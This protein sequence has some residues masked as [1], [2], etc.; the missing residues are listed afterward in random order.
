MKFTK[1]VAILL[2]VCCILIAMVGCNTPGPQGEV[3]PQGAQGVQGPQGEKGETGAQGP[4]GAQGL[5]GEKGETGAQGPQGEKGEDGKSTY[6]IYCEKYGYTGTEEEW[7]QEVYNKLNELGPQDI[8]KIAQAAV[9]TLRSY[10]YSGDLFSSGSA[11]FVDAQGTLVTA[12]HVI[13]GAY[14]LKIETFD[15][16]TY[17]VKN[18]VAFDADRDIALLRVE[19]PSENAFLKTRNSITPGEVAYSFGSSLGFLDGSFASGVIASGLHEVIIDESTDESFKEIQYTAPVSS[20]NSG[21]PILN[22]NGEAIGIVTWGYTIGDSL[23]FAT[24]ISELGELDR[25]YERSV[26]AFFHNTEYYKTKMFEDMYVESEPNNS[27]TTANLFY[28]G[29]SVRGETY[30]GAYDY[31]KITINQ[32]SDFNIAFVGDTPTIYYPL[33]INGRTDATVDLE[34]K[35]IEYDGETIYCADLYLAAGTYYIRVNG[36]YDSLATEYVLY[37]YWR[38]WSEYVDFE[39]DVSYRDMLE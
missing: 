10:N 4:Q 34:W 26:A 29:N 23:N 8:Y 18:V 28:S 32:A 15:N 14:S 13:D 16:A 22:A 9:V 19:L 2:L 12:Y 37:S 27:M 3:G 31:Y 24:H 21:G 33:L 5:Q 7:L 1:T 38:P 11:F 20:G 30:K 35:D 17:P 25:T 39:Y 36:Y 6:E